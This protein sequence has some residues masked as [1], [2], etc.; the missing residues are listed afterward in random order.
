MG[1]ST[2]RDVE[3]VADDRASLFSDPQ[4]GSGDKRLLFNEMPYSSV[5]GNL[6][7][8]SDEAIER[9]IGRHG[10]VNVVRQL[11]RDLAERE[12]EVGLLR[13]QNEDRERELRKMLVESGVSWS[14]IDKRLM[15][16]TA[17]S[18]R[19]PDIVI[20]ELM[21]E[22]L[23]SRL[24]DEEVE[25]DVEGEDE[26]EEG[27]GDVTLEAVVENPASGA[28]SNDDGNNTRSRSQST[29]SWVGYI[30]RKDENATPE[31]P[32]HLI[33]KRAQGA[34]APESNIVSSSASTSSYQDHG[35]MELND[36]VPQNIQPPT[37]LQSW[38]DHYGSQQ[39]YLT[40]RYG[41]IYDR[42]R[43]KPKE[44]D[45]DDVEASNVE[46]ESVRSVSSSSMQ[47]PPPAPPQVMPEQNGIQLSTS[48]PV[49]QTQTTASS[50]KPKTPGSSVRMLLAQLTDMHDGVQKAQTAK[51]DEFFRKVNSEPVISRGQLLGVSGAQ[52]REAG[53]GK[54]LWKEFKE[55]VSQGVPVAYRPKIWGEC[56]GA[57]TLK[58]PG[59]YDNLLNRTG[60]AEEALGQIE[61]DLYRTMPY[62]VF[63]GGNGPGVAKLR[64][65]LVAFS[66][67]NPQVGY[68]QGMNV[69]AA[70]LLLTY[71]TEE[72]AFWSL[73]SLVEN[74]LPE[75]YFSPPLLTSRADQRVFNHYFARFLPKLNEHFTNLNVQ[76]DAITFDWF[77][78]CFTD[79]LPADVLF[80]IWDVFLCVEGPV[81]LFR[82]ALALFRIHERQLLDLKT[83]AEIY[84]FMKNLVNQPVRVTEL[85]SNANAYYNQITDKDLRSHRQNEINILKQS[86]NHD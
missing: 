21:G 37:L 24:E 53:N 75:G 28:A 7:L 80:R 68:C 29:R 58:E 12:A 36:I 59:T 34:G 27:E 42:K 83:G 8:S 72:D 22:A 49:T 81:H 62:N 2:E 3:D 10:R 46:A 64:R 44:H 23:G 25:E 70:I 51:W 56:S 74:I 47:Q 66:R 17:T 31:S 86:L 6:H 82:V 1:G 40:D 50:Q 5:P 45:G 57:W 16:M 43:R 76:I 33:A 13:R 77:L 67:W 15:N 4:I 52:L 18:M 85:T 26:E 54:A 48:Q 30:L 79:A 14:D 63:F 84:S 20:N 19:K 78:S 55:L 38:N 11:A 60:E 73:V 39:D 41:F 35:P 71:A 32:E 61:L 9:F 69:I 65:V